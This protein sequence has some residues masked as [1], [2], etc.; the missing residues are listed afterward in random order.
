MT[1]PAPIPESQKSIDDTWACASYATTH[2]IE[3]Q[4]KVITG[5]TVNL[6]ARFLAIQSGTIPGVG[7]YIQKVFATIEKYGLLT[8]DDCPEPTE[9]WTNA[10]YYSFPITPELLA[11]A[12]QF[13]DKWSIDYKLALYNTPSTLN[14]LI[15]APL[16]AWVPQSTPNHFQELLD[17]K[18]VFDSYPP[19]IKPLGTVQNFNQ[20]I[21]KKKNMSNAKFVHKP[22]TQEYGFYLP[23]TT[24]ETIK[25]KALNLGREDILGADG[26]VDFS[27]AQEGI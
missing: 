21:I 8:T 22:G 6:S 11:K 25:D 24:P 20:F 19:F 18:T 23:A 15:T 17:P 5:E 27:K 13:L 2:A 1:W 10:Q 14:L 3:S 16:I 9:P 7:N 26:K 12:R 4:I